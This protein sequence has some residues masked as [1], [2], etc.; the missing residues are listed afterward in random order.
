MQDW[1]TLR[2]ELN[3][4]VAAGLEPTIC[5]SDDRYSPIAAVEWEASAGSDLLIH[6]PIPDL[7]GFARSGSIVM[8]RSVAGRELGRCG[9][10][11]LQLREVGWHSYR[12]SDLRENCWRERGFTEYVAMR[13]DWNFPKWEHLGLAGLAVLCDKW[14]TDPKAHVST[15]RDACREQWDRL[16]S[17]WWIHRWAMAEKDLGNDAEANRLFVLGRKHAPWWDEYTLG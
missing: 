3:S 16:G 7:Y 9:A 14:M 1:L 15:V 17:P 4:L 10:R 8:L 5:L 6:V 11:F 13:Y 2:D 12:F